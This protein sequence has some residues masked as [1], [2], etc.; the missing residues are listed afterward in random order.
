MNELQ[1]EG[2]FL[3][4]G[5]RWG[6]DIW[7]VDDRLNIAVTNTTDVIELPG[8]AGAELTTDQ[9]QA[10]SDTL[11]DYLNGVYTSRKDNDQNKN[12]AQN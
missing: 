4:D 1:L 8:F 9:I 2:N 12:S 6:I 3:E 7:V 5:G 11:T 10:L